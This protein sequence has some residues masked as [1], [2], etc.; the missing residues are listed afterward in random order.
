MS[1]EDENL[2]TG[3]P[4]VSDSDSGAEPFNTAQ[5]KRTGNLNTNEKKKRL[6]RHNSDDEEIQS[7]KNSAF[8]EDMASESDDG[9]S[10]NEE[11]DDENEEDKNEYEQ[12]GFVVDDLE[13]GS[14]E[15]GDESGEG[16]S[17]RARRK[18]KKKERRLKRLKQKMEDLDDEDR[19]LLRENLGMDTGPAS[20][21]SEDETAISDVERESKTS[22]F[23][24]EGAKNDKKIKKLRSKTD[25]DAGLMS[26]ELSYRMFGDSDDEEEEGESSSRRTDHFLGND[27]YES[28]DIDEFIVDD[29][30]EG[31]EG[32]RRRRK[33]TPNMSSVM[34]G[35]S[36]YQMDEAEELFGD[37]GEFLEA[38][39]VEGTEG[40]RAHAVAK[41]G[42]SKKAIL[43]EEYEPSVLKEHMMTE[44]LE[45]IR[46]KNLPERYQFLFGKRQF[47]VAEDRAEEA[48]WISNYVIKSLEQSGSRQQAAS[49]G[50]IVSAIDSVLRF[51]H[52][53]KLEPAFVQ[54]YCK[55]YWKVAGL[56]TEHLYQI[57]DLDIK[58]DKLDRK[59]KSFEVGIQRVIDS[60]GS[61][62]S[63]FI[64][65]CYVKLF[66]SPDEKTFQDLAEYF[67]L[68]APESSGLHE[69]DGN[70]P[71]YRRPGRRNYYQIG[72]KGG[73]RPL[74]QA[75]TLH[76]SVLG[77]ILAEGDCDES[78]RIIP[79]PSDTPGNLAEQYTA[80]EFQTVD[81]V[82]KG[83]RHIAAVKVAA[84][85]NV[86]KCI[87]QLYRQGARVYTETTAKGKEDIDEF[88]YCHGFQYLNGMPA[89]EIME[90]EDVWLRLHRAEKEGLI[91]I[92]IGLDKPEDLLDPLEPIYLSQSN[93]SDDF[94][95]D[96]RY[97]ILQEALNGLMIPS[98]ENEL[99]RDLLVASREHVVRTCGKGIRE[100]LMV[101]PYEPADGIDP[102]IVSIWVD[103]GMDAVASIVALDQNGELI[104]KTRGFCKREERFVQQLTNTLYKFLQDHSRTHVVVI[105]LAGGNKGMDMGELVDALRRQLGRDIAARYGNYDGSDYFDIV[106]LKDDV[107]RMYSRSKRAEIE[108]P[109]ETEAIRAAI[110]LGRY[111]RNPQS[112]LCAMWG[113]L[114]LNE[115]IRGRELL[116]LNMHEM[117]HSLVKDMLL[118]EYDRVFVQVI[119]KFGLDINL[120]ANHKH[121]SY[122]LQ[123]IA[124]L[125]PVKAA[126]ILEKV[127]ARSYIEHRQDLLS[128]GYVGKIVYRNCVGFIRIRERDALKESP[129]NPLDDTRIH[130]ES[131]Y[132]AVKMCG[133]AN[134]N[135][136]IDMYD[137]M[138]YSY[139]VEDTMF[140]SAT[141]IRNRN[142]SPHTR[143][144][145]N[146][147]Q[148]ALSELDLPAYAARLELQKK[149]PKL[150]TLEFIKRELRYPYFDKRMQYEPPSK[151][152]L[153]FLL[154]GETKQTL[155]AGMIVPC[156]L[157]NISNGMVRARLQNGILASLRSELLPDY[158][159]DDYIRANGFPR[160]AIVNCKILRFQQ[161]PHEQ[162]EAQVGCNEDS[163]HDVKRSFNQHLLVSYADRERLEVDSVARISKLVNLLTV[164]DEAGARA[165]GQ[166]G[167]GPPKRKR[168]QIAHPAFQNISCKAAM[169]FLRSKS[170]GE[171]VIRPSTIGTDHLTLSWKMLEG[172]YRHFDIEER[173]K[174]SE[175]RIGAILVIKE[176]E[177][178]NIDELLARFVDPMNELVDEV[179]RHKYFRNSSIETIHGDLIKQKKENPGRIPYILHVYDRFPGCFSI[180]F[181]ARFTPHSCHMEVKP[182]GLRFFGRVES[183]ILPTLNQA[184]QFFKMKALLA[185]TA[186][187]SKHESY[188]SSMQSSGPF[189]QRGYRDDYDGDAGR[190][191]SRWEGRREEPRDD[192]RNDR[193]DP[194]YASRYDD[195]RNT[196]QRYRSEV[197]VHGMDRRW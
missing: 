135:A 54:R 30:E 1:S 60:V 2:I 64:R 93:N 176:E 50:E 197:P 74:A 170:P 80:K 137:P 141:A 114:P 152:E 78:L 113:H 184:L 41:E 160:G 177:Y 140:Q 149:G 59:S 138:Q 123:F 178:E 87:R 13:N 58:W 116:Y 11:D 46:E 195:R 32:N 67:A 132:M 81:D 16:R 147:I 167:L 118:K 24:K 28:D 196:G 10:R 101:R 145:D 17:H 99:K 35:P 185:P 134:N 159:T 179:V 157:I 175:A 7:T 121:T 76:A 69:R 153:F 56:H 68:D 95:Q 181:V 188:R 37:M 105:N 84:E 111:L 15:D 186:S 127:R 180:T 194:G 5:K 61:K 89:H 45:L 25:D 90:A 131:Y 151:E 120:L 164:E 86:R 117:Q 133:D 182:K 156:T 165:V 100:R 187:S 144:D 26:R 34:Q 44:D 23:S 109:E 173:D 103:G 124:G 161:N 155:R 29:D 18:R 66:K 75:F 191:R 88:H 150:L 96:H 128:K 174:P 43:L 40:S 169:T 65:D 129:L 42:K 154:N 6:K 98:F 139:A 193:R 166:S 62:E 97:Q 122:Q 83:A 73:L 4:T 94:W 183:S 112:E 14:D 12:D 163:L 104:D 172:V 49:R 108:F 22:R 52:E 51:Y 85:P 125:G 72:L 136:T 102:Y 171:A 31:R 21:E 57:L 107:P 63:Q 91:V 146:E 143:L 189:P 19:L 168:R 79:T 162:W 148:D 39:R 8:I 92:N 126:F 158:M 82:L 70:A 190:S 119:N 47:P 77:G 27:E 142:A 20:E 115:P 48:E 36:V 106:F 9:D 33:Q 53:E 192:Y 130:P 3:S 110:G 38:S 71:K 55:E